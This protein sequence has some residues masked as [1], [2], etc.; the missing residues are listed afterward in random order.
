MP[1]PAREPPPQISKAILD[2]AAAAA[3]SARTNSCREPGA[4]GLEALRPEPLGGLPV[5]YSP[6]SQIDT[7]K[8]GRCRQPESA[9]RSAVSTAVRTLIAP[10]VCSRGPARDVGDVDEPAVKVE[11]EEDAPVADAPAGSIRESAK[12]D[13]VT[14][15]RI[16]RQVVELGS[17][18]LAL[19][20][21]RAAHDLSSAR[22]D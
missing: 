14:A 15:E 8:A 17:E 5:D 20:S 1:A 22:G 18:S 19:V 11:I 12:A 7:S 10:A 9:L 2:R 3:T 16:D 4:C 21:R 6:G 13:G